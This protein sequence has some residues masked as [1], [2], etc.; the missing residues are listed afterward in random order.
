[1]FGQRIELVISQIFLMF[2]VIRKQ[3]S[4]GSQS[5]RK[6]IIIGLS[7]YISIILGKI[8]QRAKFYYKEDSFCPNFCAMI[9]I[10]KLS[11]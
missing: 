6:I 2:L 5:K 1:M 7:Y 4:F 3:G 10:L 9:F 8:L 11:M